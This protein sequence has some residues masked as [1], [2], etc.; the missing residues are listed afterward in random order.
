MLIVTHEFPPYTFGGIGVFCSYLANALAAKGTEV[1]VVAGCPSSDIT[2]ARLADLRATDNN[3]EAI[4]VPRMRLPPSHLWYQLMN[5][6]TISKLVSNFDVIHG[7][8]CA[9]F[10]IISYCK[11]KNVN[12]PWIVTLHN[13]P[14]SER[15][16][17]L[18]SLASLECSLK[19][20]ATYV[21]GFPLWDISIR[22]HSKFA[23][24]LVAVSRSLSEEISRCYRIETRKLTTVHTGVDIAH[25]DGIVRCISPRQSNSNKIKIFY[26]GRLYW[27]KGILQL[28]K[29]LAYLTSKLGF[30]NFQLQVFG[31]GPL[32][33]KIRELIS[34]FNLSNNVKLRGF[35]QYQELIASMATSDIVCVPSFYEACPVAMIEG[36][37]LGKPVVAFDRPFSREL[38]G[39]IPMRMM[40]T[41]VEDYARCLY[42]LCTSEDL[43][44]KLGERLR[45]RALE[46][47]DIT[48]I[49]DEYLKLYRNLMS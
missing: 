15:Y 36:M 30:K 46:N 43:R 5:L 16:Y 14:T 23:D 34:D 47:F 48:I 3:L 22:G 26:G 1:T 44:R 38:L 2:R 13:N 31:R 41:S 11:K 28:L 12:P 9:T 8:D 19:D 6:N 24:M 21:L 7:Q 39:D 10:P 17:T 32:E 45:T 42:S 37:A 49:A 35:V 25:L 27:R 18:K 29:S 20:F 33:P 40:A 4:R